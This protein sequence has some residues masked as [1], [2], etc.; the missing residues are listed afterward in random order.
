M[1]RKTKKVLMT[2]RYGTRYGS[3]P[4]KNVRSIELKSKSK[5]RCPICRT[6]AVKRKS[7]GIWYCKKCNSL[8]TGGA[9]VLETSEG[10]KSKRSFRKTETSSSKK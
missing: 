9:W 6:K 3:T 10:K 2:G 4:R 7:N 5:F 8:L 1:T